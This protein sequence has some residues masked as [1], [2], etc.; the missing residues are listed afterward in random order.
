MSSDLV[1]ITVT[2]FTDC[3]MSKYCV[4]LKKTEQRLSVDSNVWKGIP[5]YRLKIIEY[6]YLLILHW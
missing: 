2:L 4:A 5:I 3:F 1:L 6:I